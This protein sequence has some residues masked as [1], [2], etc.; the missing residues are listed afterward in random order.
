MCQLKPLFTTTRDAVPDKHTFWKCMNFFLCEKKKCWLYWSNKKIYG[1]SFLLNDNGKS[2]PDTAISGEKFQCNFWDVIQWILWL[3]ACYYF[4]IALYDLIK[5][6][7][8]TVVI[9]LL[10]YIFLAGLS[11]ETAKTTWNGRERLTCHTNWKFIKRGG[12]F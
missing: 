10:N 6:S 5:Y 4:L 1:L 7:T 12:L 2:V 9:L 3:P 11:F 8:S